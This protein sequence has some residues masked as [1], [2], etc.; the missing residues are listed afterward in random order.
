MLADQKNNRVDRRNV[1]LDNA[2]TFAGTAAA[3]G[4]Y[5]TILSFC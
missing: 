4:K 1:G 3:V 2:G 5:N